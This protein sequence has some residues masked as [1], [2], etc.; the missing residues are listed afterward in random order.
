MSAAA[1]DANTWS[2]LLSPALR[3]IDGLG[4]AGYGRLDFRLG[5]G[6][7]L[8]FAL[9]HRISKDID[10]FFD[11]AQ[12]LGF[13]SPRL[14]GTAA[15]LGRD[16]AEQGNS[17]K[18]VLDAGD[19]DFIVAGTVIPGEPRG[20]LDYHG[21]S[22]PLD[23]ISEVLAKKLLYRA[24]SFKPRDVFDLAAVLEQD[25]PSA[26]AAI[27]ATR[28]MSDVLL[29]RLDALGRLPPAQLRSDIHPIGEAASLLDRMFETVKTA[30]IASRDGSPT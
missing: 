20:A 7:A 1:A 17:L 24:A 4:A 9:Q 12:A 10:I 29:R 22:I 19:I 5:G 14:N 11:D 16:Y 28:S 30:V 26:A 6:T 18:L 21:R 23:P 15:A 3:L 13:L 25:R 2:T 8:M 27:L